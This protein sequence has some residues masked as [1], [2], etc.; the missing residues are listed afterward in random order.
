VEPRHWPGRKPQ[1][2][3]VVDPFEPLRLAIHSA[4]AVR[5]IPREGQVWLAISGGADSMALLE[6]VGTMQGRFGVLH[7]DH[8]LHPD[9][10][11]IK[12]FV[13]AA[14]QRLGLPFKHHTLRGLQ[15]SET[16][17]EQGLEAAARSARYAWM[18]QAVGKGA[19]VL[20]AHHADD[21]RETRLLHLLRGSRPEA[22]AA[23]QPWTEDW[24]FAL[25]RPF[26]DLPK[27]AL[28][29]A[30]LA[31]GSGW[32]EDPTNLQP[33]FL[34]NR[35]RHELIPLLDSIRPGWASGLE[36]MGHLASEWR[37]HT[38]GLHTKLGTHTNT[39][40]ISLLEQAPSPT[41]FLGIWGQT[42]GFGLAQATELVDLARPDTEVGRR[43]C[44]ESHCVV[45]ERDALVAHPVEVDKER[46]P[47][48]WSPLE[49]A[50]SGTI[51]TPE[52]MLTWRIETPGDG[53][54]PDSGDGTADLN[55]DAAHWPLTLRPWAEG[56]RIAPLGMK[57]SQSVSDI[58]TQRK[59][60]AAQRPEHWVVHNNAGQ[61]L[62]LVGHRIDRRAA[63]SLPLE[64]PQHQRVLRLRWDPLR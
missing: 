24:G 13:E 64:R 49:G 18:A 25:G 38:E 52:G 8:G 48:S 55:L 54:S 32:K 9:S 56:D 23:M 50:E 57:G 44:S 45:R 61:L 40:P 59:V 27:S 41:H 35:L 28:H 22:M 31:S 14:A 15:H 58:L 29:A 5:R 51:S 11:D 43:R 39:L 20:T 60:P 4:L 12:D 33:D 6:A 42:F 21:Q 10:A 26:L 2:P 36:R 47:R 34:R 16:R 1:I 63:L 62:W 46:G 3:N 53:F 37:H 30:M 19:A 7:V 17:R